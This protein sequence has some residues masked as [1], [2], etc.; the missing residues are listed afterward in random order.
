MAAESLKKR[1]ADESKGVNPL[2]REGKK[3]RPLGDNPK[4]ALFVEGVRS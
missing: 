4:K 2:S 1:G 3:W